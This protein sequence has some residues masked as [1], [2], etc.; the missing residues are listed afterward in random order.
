MRNNKKEFE[1]IY[2]K[3]ADINKTTIKQIKD[4][5]QLAIDVAGNNNNVNFRNLFPNGKPTLEEFLMVMKDEVS[6]NYKH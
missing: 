6:K 2:K 5:M 1:K 3:L 4:E